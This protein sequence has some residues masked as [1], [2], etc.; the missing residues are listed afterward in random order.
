MRRTLA[1]S[2]LALFVVF[3]LGRFCALTPEQIEDR[4]LLADLTVMSSGVGHPR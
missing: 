1:I 4:M 3:V 2:V